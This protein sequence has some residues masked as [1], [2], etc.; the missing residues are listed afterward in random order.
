[1]ETKLWGVKIEDQ[2]R[3]GQ[4]FW[5]LELNKPFYFKGKM[6]YGVNEKIMR[7]AHRAGVKKFIVNDREIIVPD[8]KV[9]K[10]KVKDKEFEMHPSLFDKPFII[11]YL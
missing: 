8:K 5:K 11:Y 9:L 3:N 10:Q 2:I 1:M 7:E 4:L 6:V